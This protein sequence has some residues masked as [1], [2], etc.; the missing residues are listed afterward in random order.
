MSE[1]NDAP[2]VTAAAGVAVGWFDERYRQSSSRV[3]GLCLRMLGSREEAEDAVA[4]AFLKAHRARDRFDPER[5]FANW[6]LTIAS[7]VCLDRLRRRGRERRLFLAR[8]DQAPEPRAPTESP[9]QRMLAGERRRVV[10]RAIAELPERYRQVLVMRYYGELGYEE[11]AGLLGLE[12]N[13][14]AILIHRAKKRLRRE[15]AAGADGR[16][17]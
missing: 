15:L 4:E 1:G 12:R 13:H 17:R 11:I 6:I 9:L 2:A 16:E 10:R 14:V 8:A 3:L 7:H 5:P